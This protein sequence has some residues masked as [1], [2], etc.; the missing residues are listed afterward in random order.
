MQI[1]SIDYESTPRA[2]AKR[3]ERNESPKAGWE[4]ISSAGIFAAILTA[5]IVGGVA[6]A[7]WYG[8]F[9]W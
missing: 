9:L 7:I 6:V 8:W 2:R 4:F 3:M 5:V 1:S